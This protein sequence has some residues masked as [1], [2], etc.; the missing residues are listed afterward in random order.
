[1][2]AVTQRICVFTTVHVALISPVFAAKQLVTADQLGRG[3]L[4]LNIVAGYNASEFAMFGVAMLAHD[5]RYALAEEWL[6][7]VRR[8]WSATVPF[9]FDGRFYRL[10]GAIGDPK[11]FD[12]ARPLLMSAGASGAGRAF[13]ASHADLLFLV[14]VELD[15]LAPLLATVRASVPGRPIGIFTSGHV[16]CRATQREAEDYYHYVAHEMADAAAVDQ[17]LVNREGQQSIAP[18]RLAQMRDRIAAG[19]GTFPVVGSPDR[20]AEIFRQLSDAG[21]DGMAIALVNYLDELPFF[22]EHVLPRLE[23]L[24]LR[25]EPCPGRMHLDGS[26]IEEIPGIR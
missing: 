20:V 8:L 9:D 7:I 13:A 25:R 11:P 1:M 21:L 18:E 12:N 23:R 15:G 10:R 6:T 16:V 4:G 2:L 22:C 3:R 17:V 24:G 19:S 26:G 14:A 5:E